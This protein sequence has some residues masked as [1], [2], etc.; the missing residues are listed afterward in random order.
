[1]AYSDIRRTHLQVIIWENGYLQG[2]HAFRHFRRMFCRV[3][4]LK[5]LGTLNME[6]NVVIFGCKR[7]WSVLNSYRQIKERPTFT[8]IL[9]KLWDHQVL[10]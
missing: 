2:N 9:I 8:N 4:T 6:G 3:I 1:M 5:S 10:Y 7:I